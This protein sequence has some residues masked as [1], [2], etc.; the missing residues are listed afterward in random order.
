MPDRTIPSHPRGRPTWVTTGRFV[1]NADKV[2]LVD[3][4]GNTY[5]LEYVNI[6]HGAWGRRADGQVKLPRPWVYEAVT[7]KVLVEGDILVIFFM[8]GNSHRPIVMGAARSF[9]A[10]EDE[11][12]PF[13]LPEN[14]YSDGADPNALLGRLRAVNPT[15]G[16]ETGDVRW[17]VHQAAVGKVTLAM[18]AFA[19]LAHVVPITDPEWVPKGQA[20]LT[21][22]QTS[23]TEII[24]AFAALGVPLPNTSA[25]VAN[26]VTSLTPVGAPYLSTTLKTE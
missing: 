2:V 16:I 13:D 22:L 21:D 5:A 9:E 18:S 15:T 23:L 4:S 1:Q 3:R 26:I 11:V 6:I 10:P 20:L 19:E 14:H 17:T 12:V 7:E 25:L 24:A 8:D